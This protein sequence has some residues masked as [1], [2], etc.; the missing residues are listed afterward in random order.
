MIDLLSNQ[1]FDQEIRSS[2]DQE[3]SKISNCWEISWKINRK[4]LLDKGLVL[5]ASPSGYDQ[6]IVAIQMGT[7]LKSSSPS[8]KRAN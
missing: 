4:I 7:T 2:I 1:E 6:A 8:Y 3:L 5:V